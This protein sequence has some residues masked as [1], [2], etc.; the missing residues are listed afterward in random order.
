[1]ADRLSQKD[2]KVVGLTEQA[3]LVD[4]EWPLSTDWRTAVHDSQVFGRTTLLY[5]V[6]SSDHVSA[7]TFH[8]I[9]A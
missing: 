5:K 2:A 6:D 1:M 3:R 4:G 8:S 9:V 7:R